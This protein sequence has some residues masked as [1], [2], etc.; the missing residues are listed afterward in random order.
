MNKVSSISKYID[1]ID[2]KD[3]DSLKFLIED[4]IRTN[5]YHQYIVRKIISQLGVRNHIHLMG[6]ALKTNRTEDI[7]R[8]DSTQ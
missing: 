2:L 1:K 5:P 7:F 6:P 4:T 3:I 8:T